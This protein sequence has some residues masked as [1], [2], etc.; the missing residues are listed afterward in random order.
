MVFDS[1]TEFENLLYKLSGIAGYKAKKNERGKKSSPLI[2]PAYYEDKT[3]RRNENVIGWAGWCAVDVD[4]YEG[5]YKDMLK[6][7]E[8]LYYVCY[9]S[10]SSKKSHPKFRLVFPLSRH[11]K[12]DEIKH[13]WFAL[14][15]E[16]GEIA[17]PQ[18]K[19]LSRMY[20]VPAQY[21]NAFNFIFT[22]KGEFLNV[23]DVI[24]RHEY[25]EK[26]NYNS[27]LD[28]LPENIRNAVLKQRKESLNNTNI[29]WTSY[30]DCPFVPKNLVSEYKSIAFT[31]G[32]GRYSM[33]YKIMVMIACNAIRMNYPIRAGQI[34][35][36][37]RQLDRDTSNIYTK[38]PLHIEA[39][40]ALDY[41]F[42]QSSSLQMT[43]NNL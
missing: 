17:D 22:N 39:N 14:N 35:D 41:A 30:L 25:V 38:R 6:R 8:H 31:D 16:L 43:I 1:W 4:E 13:F 15:K 5:D 34:V 20:Y 3:K 11:V 36:L 2:S 24:S 7:Y 12:K 28:R 21:P 18:T 40:R 33:I 10:A 42:S 19:D 9:S 23:D 37:I 27:F 32:S 26:N 29:T